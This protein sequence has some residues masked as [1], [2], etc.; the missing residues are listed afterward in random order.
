MSSPKTIP[1]SLQTPTP[2]ATLRR[3]F[4][5]IVLMVIVCGAAHSWWAT[6]LD[7]FTFDE[8]YHIAA[9]ATY[10]RLH[11]FRVNREHPP[12]VKFV[13][14]LA[15]PPSVLHL[16][17]LPHFEGKEQERE[18]SETAVYLQSDPQAI[19]HRARITMYP[20]HSLLLLLLALLLRRL[21]NPGIAI[22]TLCILLL[23]PTVAAHLPVVMTDLPLALLGAI[24]VVLA[25]LVLRD[26]RWSDSIFLGISAGLTLATKHSALLVVFAIVMGCALFVVYLGAKHLPWKRLAALLIGS[27]IVGGITLW[28]VYGFR[29]T[30]SAPPSSNSTV[31]WN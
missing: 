16:S 22:A 8:V 1:A 5:L 9:G 4:F 24:S 31:P 17:A 25:I 2:S 12:L 28:G 19:Q 29:Y 11:D 6:A 20:F 30:E 26:G 14:G 23:D 13:A 27:A 10:L 3:Y 18:Y 21:F 7:G 15:M